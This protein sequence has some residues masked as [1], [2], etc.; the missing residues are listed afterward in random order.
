MAPYATVLFLVGIAGLFWLDRRDNWD[1]KANFVPFFWLLISMSR[2]VTAWTSAPADPFARADSYLEGSPLDRNILMVLI[3]LAIV[4]LW[5][6]REATMAILRRNTPIILFLLYCLISVFWAEYPVVLFKRWIRA[7]G[8]VMMILIILTDRHPETALKSTISR[9]GYFLVPLSILFIRFFPE[10]GRTYSV[11]GRAMWTGVCT[12]KNALGALCM[13]VGAVVL[14]RLM[15]LRRTSEHRLAKLT[16]LMTVFLM[17]VYL[18]PLVDSKTA[19]MCFVFATVVVVFR[20][21]FRRPWAIFSFTVATV[22][23]CYAVLILGVGGDAL[24]TIGREATL[25]GRTDVWQQVL[26]F[27]HDPPG[28]LVRHSPWL[29]AGYENFWIGERAT[30][31]RAFGGNQAH[32]G[33]LEIYVNLGW[34]GLIF[35]AIV[36]L[37]GYRTMIAFCRTHPELGRLKVAFFVICLT[38]N[39]SE[40]AFK[41]MTPVWLMFLWATLAASPSP[42]VSV[43]R[44]SSSSPLLTPSFAPPVRLK[45]G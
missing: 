29:G 15:D 16:A 12:D 38:Y 19:Q 17:V 41:M 27:A 9:V 25:T 5:R 43:A 3:A 20:G 33:Y 36:I 30:R 42:V 8:D 39:F 24:E 1:S 6:R 26:R 32:N 37:A 10:L 18:L 44:R 45:A 23:V 34:M 40:A 31:L 28:G 11:G 21:L 14:W 2:P 7:V 22:A 4:V 13:V 35:L